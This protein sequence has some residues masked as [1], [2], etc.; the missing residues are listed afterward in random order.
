M[1][2]VRIAINGFGRI[3]RIATRVVW[4]N[5]LFELVAVNSRSDADMYAHLLKYDSIYG[6]WEHE[7]LHEDNEAIVIDDARVPLHLADEVA[8]APWG[9]YDVDVV[10]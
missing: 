5:P 4:G 10:I 2:P 7:V 1:K 8:G 6:P 9:A 3:G